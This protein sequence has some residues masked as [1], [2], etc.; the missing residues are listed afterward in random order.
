MLCF[1]IYTGV[2]LPTMFFVLHY[3]L[4]I[5]T[6][7]FFIV[8]TLF[9]DFITVPSLCVS[10][11]PLITSCSSLWYAGALFTSSSVMLIFIYHL[12]L[13]CTKCCV[14]VSSYT[15]GHCISSSPG[16]HESGY[17]NTHVYKI[18]ITYT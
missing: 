17:C 14:C 8:Q 13:A 10:V 4:S 3:L 18:Y 7:M 16:T 5:T 6:S 1:G 2:S 15:N 9:W 12:S 11:F